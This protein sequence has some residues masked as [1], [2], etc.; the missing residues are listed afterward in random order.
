MNYVKIK[1]N[2]FIYFLLLISLYV[3]MFKEYLSIFLIVLFHELCHIITIKI[4]KGKIRTINISPIGCLIEFNKNNLLKYQK[5]II[6]F[7]GIIGNFILLLILKE[8]YLIKF[9][10]FM[11]VFNLL[12]IFP[13]DGYRII[14]EIL[15]IFYEPEYLN[16]IM[17]V[18]V[19][20]NIII[21]SIIIFLLKYY[22]Y[23]IIVLYLLFKNIKN[24]IESKKKNKMLFLKYLTR[25]WEDE[26]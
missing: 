4:F 1:V 15:D 5:I 13:L 11:I 2:Y 14:Y 8:N 3:G 21:F 6:Y 22:G 18:V 20:I 26:I 17:L 23:F 19:I 24:F 16:D 25:L 7:M 9:N 12:I 10:K